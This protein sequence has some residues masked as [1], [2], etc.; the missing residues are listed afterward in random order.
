MARAV[1]ARPT[2]IGGQGE[3]FEPEALTGWDAVAGAGGAASASPSSG[4]PSCAGG[5]AGIAPAAEGG[6]VSAPLPPVLGTPDDVGG[7]DSNSSG[8]LVPPGGGGGAV[9][10]GETVVGVGWRGGGSIGSESP[11]TA[12]STWPVTQTGVWSLDSE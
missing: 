8:G 1:A 4:V 5:E 9:F 10:D 7:T 6:A 2:P 3:G 11:E 12:T